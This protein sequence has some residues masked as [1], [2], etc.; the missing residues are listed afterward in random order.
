MKFE[1]SRRL[2]SLVVATLLL[3]AMMLGATSCNN[4]SGGE[5]TTTTPPAESTTVA[6]PTLGEG[7][8]SFI[9]EV[10]F[11]DG[12]TKAYTVKTDA[13]T[14]GDALLGVGL[15]AGEE[16][17]YGLYVKTV[18]GVT[19]DYDTD[20][21]YW[22]FYENGEYAMAGVDSTNITAGATYAFRAAE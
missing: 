11:V 20:K 19:L 4:M 6:S 17:P 3:A 22:A 1:L 16:G 15:I 7:A 18:D 13:T 10:T 9:F 14:V 5:D 12:T 2:L 21:K 8:T